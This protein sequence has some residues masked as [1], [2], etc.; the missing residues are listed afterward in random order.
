MKFF[1]SYN[2]N[3][4]LPQIHRTCAPHSAALLSLNVKSSELATSSLQSLSIVH[5]ASTHG[6]VHGQGHGHGQGAASDFNPLVSSK[7]LC[8]YGRTQQILVRSNLWPSVFNFYVEVII[9]QMITSLSFLFSL[10]LFTMLRNLPSS[11][12]NT[13]YWPW[14]IFFLL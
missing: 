1:L 9:F 14:N 4:K 3:I 12:F 11:R 10:P 7:W 5:G 13:P 6:Q 8:L 2:F